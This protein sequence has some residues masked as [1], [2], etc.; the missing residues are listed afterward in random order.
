MDENAQEMALVPA[1]A[2]LQ[3]ALR[4]ACLALGLGHNFGER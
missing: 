1:Q 2:D 3:V 4:G